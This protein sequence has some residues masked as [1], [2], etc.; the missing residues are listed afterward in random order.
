MLT[1]QHEAHEVVGLEA[2]VESDHEG[3]VK[4][5]ADVLLVLH[6]VLLLIFADELFEHDLHGVE[7]PVSQAAHQVD[8]AEAPDG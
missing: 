2:V 3:V 1:F 6:D 8:L 7:L 4:L 5:R